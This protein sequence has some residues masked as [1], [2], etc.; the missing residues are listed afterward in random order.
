[1]KLTPDLQHHLEVQYLASKGLLDD[2]LNNAL[3]QKDNNYPE[4]NKYLTYDTSTVVGELFV[5]T[6]S[7]EGYSYWESVNENF[8][9]LLNNLLKEES[10]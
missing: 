7:N 2:T 8:T 5:W 10:K 4:M 6:E 9:K 1:M 3:N